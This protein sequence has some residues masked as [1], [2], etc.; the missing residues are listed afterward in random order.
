MLKSHKI[1]IENLQKSEIHLQWDFKK[2]KLLSSGSLIQEKNHKFKDSSSLESI[3]FS[4]KDTK[5]SS[6]DTV[7]SLKRKIEVARNLKKIKKL[8]KL[9]ELQKNIQT[10]F[11]KN[12]I[13][14][15]ESILLTEKLEKFLESTNKLSCFSCFFNKKNSEEKIKIENLFAFLVSKLETQFRDAL[16]E[17]QTKQIMSRFEEQ[18]RIR[19]KKYKNFGFG[20]KENSEKDFN[21]N[22]NLF[23][24]N[25]IRKNIENSEENNKQKTSENELDD[26]FDILDNIEIEILINELEK[27]NSNFLLKIENFEILLRL[28]TDSFITDSNRNSIGCIEGKNLLKFPEKDKEFTFY[29]P[30]LDKTSSFYNKRSY[31]NSKIE[32]P[33]DEILNLLEPLD[34]ESYNSDRNL[35]TEF[36]L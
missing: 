15:N 33:N 29:S 3:N 4:L 36:S 20:S 27:K 28:K 10:I 14:R 34:N 22:Y 17:I 1:I 8:Q 7:S 35:I 21:K 18:K 6:N 2:G 23:L 5:A 16:K 32:D 13:L 12:L 24:I 11:K 26:S 30:Q 19:R 25:Q 31:S 9:E